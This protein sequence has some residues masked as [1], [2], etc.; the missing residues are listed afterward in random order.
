MAVL[1]GA[2]NLIISAVGGCG[3]QRDV[4]GCLCAVCVVSPLLLLCSRS[5]QVSVLSVIS[6]IAGVGCA[7]L[8]IYICIQGSAAMPFFAALAALSVITFIIQVPWFVSS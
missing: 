5:Q 3:E 4:Y 2:F 1:V 8:N 6:V 7:A